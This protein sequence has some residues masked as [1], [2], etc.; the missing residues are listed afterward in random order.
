MNSSTLPFLTDAEIAQICEP[1]R[2]PGAQC[3]YLKKLGLMVTT[4]PNGRALIARSEF[5]RVLGAARFGEPQSN[6]QL[7][8]NPAALK[9]YLES[10][11]NG[12]QAQRR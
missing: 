4:K 10:R 8:P 3:R 2:L 9:N 11:K 12:P 5:E 7:G 6:A 1:L